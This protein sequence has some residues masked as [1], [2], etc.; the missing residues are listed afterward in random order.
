MTIPNILVQLSV[1]FRTR[2][3]FCDDYVRVRLSIPILRHLLDEGGSLGGMYF[4]AIA[5]VHQNRT[6]TQVGSYDED[7]IADS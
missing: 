3:L 6:K 7:C 4:N 1:I 2:V 5:R